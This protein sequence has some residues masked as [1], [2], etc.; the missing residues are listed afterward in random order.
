MGAAEKQPWD[1]LFATVQVSRLGQSIY[2]P[3]PTA[4]ELDAAEAELGCRLPA[5]YRA[6]AERCGLHGRLV[7]WLTLA[8]VDRPPRTRLE[9]VPQMTRRLRK[10]YAEATGLE[11]DAADL[12]TRLVY[13]GRDYE[14]R[15]YGFDPEDV[16]DPGGPDYRY[17]RFRPRVEMP[18][19]TLPSHGPEL[20]ADSFA[21]LVRWVAEN[22]RT[23]YPHY[24][25]GDPGTIPYDL[26]ALWKKRR[27]TRREVAGW[28]LWNN[29]TVRGLARSIR[30]DGRTDAFPILAD[31]LEEA[32]CRNKHFLD[33]CRT[34]DPDTDGVWVLMILLGKVK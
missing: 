16:T 12:V 11:P 26:G 1:E 29:G 31:A 34:G 3:K 8:P 23:D 20:V 24:G 15:Y 33:S 7:N 10:K 5:G 27:P 18:F 13:F 6:F 22:V 14:S 19:Q 32:G 25:Q 9:T 17:Y 4:T 21:G 28:L 2:P 30:E